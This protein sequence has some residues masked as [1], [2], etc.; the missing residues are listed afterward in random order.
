MCLNKSIYFIIYKVLHTNFVMKIY[1]IIKLLSYKRQ[2][3]ED[4]ICV[5][6]SGSLQILFGR[7]ESIS[8]LQHNG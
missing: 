7:I 8:S 3:N 2:C 5:M 6:V 4:T 1:V